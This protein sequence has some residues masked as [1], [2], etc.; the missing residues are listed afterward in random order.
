MRNAPLRLL[1]RW[2]PAIIAAAATLLAAERPLELKLA[3]DECWWGGWSVDGPRMPFTA[4]TQLSRNLYGNDGTN[5]AQP[6]LI[7]SHGRFVWSEQPFKFEFSAG[8]LRISDARGALVADRAGKTLPEAFRH[9]ARRYFPADGRMPEPLMFTRPQY[10]TWIELMYDQ[11]QADILKYARAIKAQGYPT[12]VLM[13]DDN[14]QEDYGNWTFSSRRFPD[15][16]AMMAELHAMGFR[17]MLWVCPFVSADSAI[18]RELEQKRLVLM[19]PA[20]VSS[21]ASPPAPRAAIIRWWNGAS[22]CLDLTH[23]EARAWFRR[24]LDHLRKEYG[25]EGFKFDAGDAEFYTGNFASHAPALPNDHTEMFGRVGLDFPLNEYR[26]SWKN[27]G[28]P[29]AQRLR[30]KAHQWEDLQTLV[31]GILAQGLMGYAFT[32]PDLI[33]GGEFTSFLP[34]AKID[35]E[36]IVRSAQVHAL[37]PMMQF[38]VAPWRILSRENNAICRAMAEL[39]VKFADPLLA[40]ARDA[41]RTGEPIVRPLCW[42]WPSAGYETI[43]DQFMLGDDIL[44]A[45][46]VQSG[47]RRRSVIFPPGTWR[48]DDGS[49]VVGPA[50]REIEVPLARLPWYRKT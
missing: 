24:Q 7:S 15:P 44:V 48:G 23:P 36:L 26:A 3:P 12:G 2:P 22:A 34:G 39:H 21:P 10:N 49:T 37:M 38:S 19:E 4:G 6:L 33:G 20:L 40:M 13:I 45:P 9:V 31:P 18:F 11:N 25:V 42:L 43:T 5:Q 28:K 35:Q 41:A 47:A 46:V 32:C 50:T 8:T 16:K 30:D 14:W 1:L 17:V 29:L 27:A